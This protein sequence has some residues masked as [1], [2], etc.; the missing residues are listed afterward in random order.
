METVHTAMK[1]ENSGVSEECWALC[2]YFLR[3]VF[4]LAKLT[5]SHIC[6][7]DVFLLFRDTSCR[8]VSLRKRGRCKFEQLV[9][10]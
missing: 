10:I 4:I 5:A 9:T 8:C 1:T 3:Y 7:F 2:L 6:L